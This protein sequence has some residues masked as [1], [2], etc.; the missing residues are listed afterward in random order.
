VPAL[1]AGVAAPT[2]GQMLYLAGSNN[3]D[4]SLAVY[5]DSADRHLTNG[6]VDANFNTL[7]TA[8]GWFNVDTDGV[9]YASFLTFDAATNTSHKIWFLDGE[10]H[11]NKYS[12]GTGTFPASASILTN[13]SPLNGANLT[14]G[15]VSVSAL[16]G[17]GTPSSTTYWRGDG[18]W[19]TPS[20]GGSS[21]ATN[22]VLLMTS[23]NIG[24]IAQS[25]T[26]YSGWSNLGNATRNGISLGFGG[27]IIGMTYSWYD[28]TSTSIGAGTNLLIGLT[29]DGTNYTENINIPISSYTTAFTS[30][31]TNFF[32]STPIQISKTNSVSLFED[33]TPTGSSL[34]STS[35]FANSRLG[36]LI[37]DMH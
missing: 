30:G 37:K 26:P 19:A 29:I 35:V 28:S 17:T 31:S 23:G 9:V 20:G 27:K 13:G 33:L 22:Y 18:V 34:P 4:G 1:A 6:T 24:S 10:I 11:G 14:S 12:D 21:S 36:I 5:P 16:N 15:T 25:F 3:A 8:S 7:S 2:A 32:F